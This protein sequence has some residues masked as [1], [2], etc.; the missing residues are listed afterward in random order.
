MQKWIVVIGVGLGL[1][2]VATLIYTYECYQR[3][4]GQEILYGLWEDQLTDSST[5]LDLRSNGSFAMRETFLGELR[6]I[7]HGRW[8]AGGTKIY[9]GYDIEAPAPAWPLPPMIL[10]IVDIQPDELR[11]RHSPESEIQTFRRVRV[12]DPNRS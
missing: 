8:Y 10:Y 7:G 12:A 11:I 4:P 9:L 3:G 6:E 1:G 5:Y 2:L